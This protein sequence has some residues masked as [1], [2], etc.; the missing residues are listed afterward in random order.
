MISTRFVNPRQV[1]DGLQFH[2]HHSKCCTD[3]TVS[4]HKHSTQLIGD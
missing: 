3:L 2:V 4:N 1:T